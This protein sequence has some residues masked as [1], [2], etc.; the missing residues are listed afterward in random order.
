MLP[1]VN[2]DATMSLGTIL[3]LGYFPP[4]LCAHFNVFVITVISLASSNTS[5]D[6]TLGQGPLRDTPLY[7][8]VPS[9]VS[10]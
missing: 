3:G 5:K 2:V 1:R 9:A 6:K 4:T 10:Y 8:R 7:D